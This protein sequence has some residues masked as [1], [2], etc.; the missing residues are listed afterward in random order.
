MIPKKED[1]EKERKGGLQ[2]GDSSDSLTGAD[3]AL[4]VVPLLWILGFP[5]NMIGPSP[6]SSP[7]SESPGG[8]DGGRCVGVG[9]RVAPALVDGP[10]HEKWRD[11]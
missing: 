8:I 5:I 11:E 4:S 9:E 10:S 1:T 7:A 3:L 2:G 6:S